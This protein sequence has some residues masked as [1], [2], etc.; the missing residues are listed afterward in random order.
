MNKL[1]IKGI[2]EFI[3]ANEKRIKIPLKEFLYYC[4]IYKDEYP[5]NIKLKNLKRDWN[6]KGYV[7]GFAIAFNVF[8][9]LKKSSKLVD[10]LPVQEMF[11]KLNLVYK[12]NNIEGTETLLNIVDDFFINISLPILKPLTLNFEAIKS[13]GLGSL[14]KILSIPSLMLISTETGKNAD[15]KKE[16]VKIFKDVYK[17][18]SL[19]KLKYKDRYNER[20][21][22]RQSET[23]KETGETKTV[24]LKQLKKLSDFPIT[25]LVFGGLLLYGM[26]GKK[27]KRKK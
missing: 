8:N 19:P 25:A 12:N 18:P 23:E 6:K 17:I 16:S 10:M 20:V 26:M 11:Y 3:K 7:N 22:N 4:Y 2:T 13:L 1:Q 15:L 21:K 9:K 24:D 14:S 5:N 27:D